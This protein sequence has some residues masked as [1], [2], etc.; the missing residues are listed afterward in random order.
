[1]TSSS[2]CLVLKLANLDI[3]TGHCAPAQSSPFSLI[4]LK[5]GR[6]RVVRSAKA[7]STCGPVNEID[8]FY[9]LSV[10]IYYKYLVKQ[11]QTSPNLRKCDIKSCH[12]VEGM[13]QNFCT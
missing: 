3:W 10:S 9:I 8:I 6:L 11:L 5:R 1:M 7:P 2:M 12:V 4:S 13:S